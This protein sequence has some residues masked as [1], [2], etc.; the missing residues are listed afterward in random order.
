[1]V[2]WTGL[3]LSA[4]LRG[5]GVLGDVLGAVNEG[6]ADSALGWDYLLTA[7]GAGIW[8]GRLGGMVGAEGKA[9]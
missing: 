5:W 2:L 6:A 7:L 8:A 3:G 4:V 1:M 9:E